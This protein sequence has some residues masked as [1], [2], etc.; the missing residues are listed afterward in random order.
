MWLCGLTVKTTCS[1]DYRRIRSNCE[2]ISKYI[3]LH[4]VYTCLQTRLW[5]SLRERGA[6]PRGQL[7]MY[8]NR[9]TC[10]VTICQEDC[11][12]DNHRQ[13]LRNTTS[14]PGSQ[15]RILVNTVVSDI[16]PL[17]YPVRG[18]VSNSI[19]EARRFPI[20]YIMVQFFHLIYRNARRCDIASI[21]PNT[22]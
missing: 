15:A 6:R 18:P 17:R 16:A 3:E 12:R 22:A 2:W 19:P 13:L 5:F 4:V 10:T 20:S 14:W 7:H 21:L 1:F 8:S 9:L 11:S